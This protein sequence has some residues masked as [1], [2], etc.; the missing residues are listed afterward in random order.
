MKEMLGNYADGQIEFYK[1]VRDHYVVAV[2]CNTELQPHRRWR[3]GTGSYQS[4][5]AY[6]LTFDYADAVLWLL[7]RCILSL[8]YRGLRIYIVIE[9]LDADRPPCP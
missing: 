1:A 2:P 8:H 9:L 6:G 4:S 5:N 7:S 3:S